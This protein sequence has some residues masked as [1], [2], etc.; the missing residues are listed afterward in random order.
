MAP[1]AREPGLQLVDEDVGDPD[2]GRGQGH[3]LDLVKVLRVPHQELIRPGLGGPEPQ[4]V[5]EEN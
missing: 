4:L 5:S 1:R 2:V 3:L